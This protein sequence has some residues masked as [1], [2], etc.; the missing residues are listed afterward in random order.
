MC[1]SPLA[2]QPLIL[3]DKGIAQP[4]S[5]AHFAENGQFCFL[6]GPSWPCCTY[7][8]CTM[9]KAYAQCEAPRQCNEYKSKLLIIRSVQIFMTAGVCGSTYCMLMLAFCRLNRMSV[10]SFKSLRTIQGTY[11][12]LGEVILSLNA[13]ALGSHHDRM[14]PEQQYL[15]RCFIQ[16]L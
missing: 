11:L 7:S 8:G 4:F 3:G 5:C 16:G 15:P 6:H 10:K 9:G 13:M 1:A 2:K 14:M 12:T